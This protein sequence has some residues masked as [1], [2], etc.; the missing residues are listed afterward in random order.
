MSFSRTARTLALL[1]VSA[2]GALAQALPTT[3]P[4]ILQIIREQVT[5]FIPRRKPEPRE[6]TT[7]RVHVPQQDQ[8]FETQKMPDYENQ[9]QV[10][11]TWKPGQQVLHPLWGEGKITFCSGFGED[12]MLTISFKEGTKKKVMAKYAKLT[13]AH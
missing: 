9:S 11:V 3:Q 13:L 10:P 6:E 1:S 4:K 8:D 2:S 5:D 7:A 12:I